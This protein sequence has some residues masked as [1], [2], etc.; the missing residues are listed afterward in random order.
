V[1]ETRSVM[2]ERVCNELLKSVIYVYKIFPDENQVLK[3]QFC[4]LQLESIRL[5]IYVVLYFK[6]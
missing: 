6:D 5:E 4:F 2:G 3:T 1:L